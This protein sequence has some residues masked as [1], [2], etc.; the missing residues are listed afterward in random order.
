ML[1]RVETHPLFSV[2][3]KIHKYITL[4]KIMIHPVKCCRDL[5]WCQVHSWNGINFTVCMFIFL[6]LFFSLFFS[7]YVLC[8]NLDDSFSRYYKIYSVAPRRLGI[9]QIIEIQEWLYTA[10]LMHSHLQWRIGILINTWT[11]NKSKIGQLIKFYHVTQQLIL[12][13]RQ[14][15]N[16][17]HDCCYHLYHFAH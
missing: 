17:A 12:H 1:R 11:P 2:L 15:M 5:L 6:F 14:L 3:W 13:C 9:Y 16:W 8:L 10:Y 7:L 4:G